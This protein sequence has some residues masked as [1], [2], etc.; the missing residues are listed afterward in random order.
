MRPLGSSGSNTEVSHATHERASR[1]RLVSRSPVSGG[2]ASLRRLGLS[3]ERASLAVTK[4]SQRSSVATTH[5]RA[6][7]AADFKHCCML[8]GEFD[9]SDRHHF[10]QRVMRPSTNH[11]IGQLAM[12]ARTGI[13][14]TM[15]NSRLGRMNDECWGTALE[16]HRGIYL[17][18]NTAGRR[19]Y[20]E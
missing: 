5:A 17:A 14:S 2:R 8:S 4:S 9:G 1:R 11:S 7:L 19:R 3:A 15:E 12:N 6:T 18:V 16:S 10:F 13:D 20:P